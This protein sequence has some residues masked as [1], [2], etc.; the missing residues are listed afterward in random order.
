MPILAR[1]NFDQ[2]FTLYIDVSGISFRV[3][4]IQYLEG[5]E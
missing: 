4:L 3:T 1:P 2:L 5:K